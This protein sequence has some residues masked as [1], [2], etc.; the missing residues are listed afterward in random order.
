MDRSYHVSV[1]RSGYVGE[2]HHSGGA[3][4]QRAQRQIFRARGVIAPAGRQGRESHM[5][6]RFY[7]AGHYDFASGVDDFFC[8]G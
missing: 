2:V 6:M 1:L 3:S 7:T 8:F 5:G 4:P